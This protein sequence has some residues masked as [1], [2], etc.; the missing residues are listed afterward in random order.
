MTSIAAPAAFADPITN[1]VAFT[2]CR[3]IWVGVTGNISAVMYGD[4]ATRIF[5]NVPVGI[6]PIQC[7]KVNAAGTTASSLLALR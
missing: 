5:S 2:P 4:G 1:D 7:T 6:L 3:S